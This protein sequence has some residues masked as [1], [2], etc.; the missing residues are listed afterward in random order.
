MKR[1]GRVVMPVNR[2]NQV[3]GE[4]PCGRQFAAQVG[5][6]DAKN[7]SFSGEGVFVWIVGCGFS[8]GIGLLGKL[9]DHR[10]LA[11]VVEQAQRGDET[12]IDA[13]GSCRQA[14]GRVGDGQGVDPDVLRIL[15]PLRRL[16]LQHIPQRKRT[17][18]DLTVAK[19]R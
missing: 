19:P 8:Q 3:G 11:D 16:R 5:V 4:L 1:A 6:I 12:A 18:I 10:Q 7:S 9:G 14:L 13:G 17:T 15:P 2:L